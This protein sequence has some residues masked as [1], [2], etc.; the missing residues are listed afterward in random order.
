[1]VIFTL[2]VLVAVAACAAEKAKPSV[3]AAASLEKFIKHP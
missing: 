3:M 1:M 2:K